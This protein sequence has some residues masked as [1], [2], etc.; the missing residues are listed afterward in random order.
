MTDTRRDR[1]AVEEA[2]HTLARA[3]LDL[4]TGLDVIESLLHPDY[5]IIQP[6]G[7]I[8]T[9]TDV[10][11]SYRTGT[12]HW[13]TA[14]VDQLRSTQYGATIIVVGRW[15]ASGYNGATWFDYQARFASVWIK[16]GS[17]WQNITYQ[18]T[19]ITV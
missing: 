8:E 1:L 17:R 12:R 6:G 7:V 15:C 4:A 10:L 19:E 5:V 13:D 9:K 14:Q 11:A 2:E 3:H 16:T 18:S